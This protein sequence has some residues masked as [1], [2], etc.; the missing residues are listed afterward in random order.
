M[1]RFS[2]ITYIALFC[3]SSL[4]AQ[5]L[6]IPSELEAT[7]GNRSI[8]FSWKDINDKPADIKALVEFCKK[9]PCKVNLIQYN[10]VDN[11]Q[12]PE[13]SQEVINDYIE[14][15]NFYNIKVTYRKSR[16]KDIDAACG[17]LANKLISN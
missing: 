10:P 2:I 8:F 16:G 14:S 12:T 17:Q 3:F 4:I 11:F 7:S 5:E 6:C 13:A 1:S 9:I 15:L